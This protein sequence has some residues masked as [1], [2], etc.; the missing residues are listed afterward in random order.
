MS[1]FPPKLESDIVGIVPYYYNSG[2]IYKQYDSTSTRSAYYV[3]GNLI[4]YVVAYDP[5]YTT[6]W[7]VTRKVPCR[8]IDCTPF[9]LL[10]IVAGFLSYKIFS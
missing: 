4:S 10:G 3:D 9:F 8:T 1:E 5:Q 6:D 7:S 2:K